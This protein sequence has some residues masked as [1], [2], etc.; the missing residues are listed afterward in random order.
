M[1]S[2]R[3]A[4]E[5]CSGSLGS[6]SSFS[7]AVLTLLVM[8]SSEVSLP[9]LLFLLIKRLKQHPQRSPPAVLYWVPESSLSTH[10]LCKDLYVQNPQIS[11]GKKQLSPTAHLYWGNH[12]KDPA[13]GSPSF[14]LHFCRG[15][16]LTHSA[17]TKGH[18][19]GRLPSLASGHQEL[20][21]QIP[22]D[23]GTT[24]AALETN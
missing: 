4:T 7:L 17:A 23:G 14:S 8:R 22:S 1:W 16:C 12:C 24:V 3:D 11:T 20:L 18:S 15:A 13:Q 9:G 19:L 21:E 5:I 6:L 2:P 10:P